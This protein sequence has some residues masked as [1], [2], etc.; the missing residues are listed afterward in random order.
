ML[1][2]LVVSADPFL[3]PHPFYHHLSL[4]FLHLFDHRLQEHL[5]LRESALRLQ[6]DWIGLFVCGWCW[7]G[8]RLQEHL[9]YVRCYDL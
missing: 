7:L 3:C 2:L 9:G 5:H 1:M 6:D 8:R 4:C